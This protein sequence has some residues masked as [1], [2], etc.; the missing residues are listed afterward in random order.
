MLQGFIERTLGPLLDKP[1]LLE[2]L[3][4]VLLSGGRWGE[5][6]QKLGVHR[7]TL[8]Y[9][10]AQ[11]RA[12]LGRDP[13]EASGQLE[14]WLALLARRALADRFSAGGG[15]ASEMGPDLLSG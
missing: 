12:L 2:S 14:I 10:S 11:A 9:R 5:A 3:T 7:H 8:R 15:S 1:R 4:A 13:F 6:A